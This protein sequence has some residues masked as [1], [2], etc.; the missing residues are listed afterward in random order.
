MVATQYVDPKYGFVTSL[1]KP[2]EPK[3]R[4]PRVFTTRP[5]FA[6][7]KDREG[8]KIDFDVISLTTVS[9]GYMVVLCEGRRGEGFYVCGQCGA[10]FRRMENKHKT[11]YG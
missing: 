6:G 7:F 1:E 4:P 10:G 3:A 5:Y 2:E 11:P 8:D 9:P